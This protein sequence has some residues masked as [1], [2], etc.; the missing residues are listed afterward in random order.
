MMPQLSAECFRKATFG[1][2]TVR[3][4][5]S[6][7]YINKNINPRGRYQK[8]NQSLTHDTGITTLPDSGVIAISG[9]N[10][11]V[12]LVVGTWI[13]KQAAAQGCKNLKFKFLSR[14]CKISDQN[15]PQWNEA[16]AAAEKFGFE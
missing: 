3:I 10:G 4:L 11:A 12:A 15:L 1:H 6:G 16:Q 7:R 9:G 14:S 8:A 2:A 13:M 5:K